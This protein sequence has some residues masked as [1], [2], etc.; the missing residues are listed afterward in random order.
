MEA[1][2][3]RVLFA[4]GDFDTTFGGGDGAAL[5]HFT[6]DDRGTTVA[7]LAD[8][9]VLVGGSVATVGTPG[10]DWG[11]AKLKPDGTPDT[12]FG[13]GGLV[14]IDFG[15]GDS[16]LNAI[17]VAPDGKIV[18]VGKTEAN[19]TADWAVARLTAA[20]ALDPTFGTAGSG[21]VI[22]DFFGFAD[23]AFAVDVQSNNRIVVT[24]TDTGVNQDVAVVRYTTTGDLDTTFDGDGKNFINFFG[25]TD[26]AGAVRVQPDNKIIVVGG[27]QQPG[28]YRRFV[29]TRFN[30]NGSFDSTFGTGGEATADFGADAFA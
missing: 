30:A 11:I 8:G 3:S 4:A 6:P 15:T 29:L 18:A 19:G 23:E 7:T 9:S 28:S 21:K 24:G 27:S 22:T 14:T 16:N 17:A 12:T 2:E 20:G 26:Y 1:L 5:V 13:T 25:G 10:D